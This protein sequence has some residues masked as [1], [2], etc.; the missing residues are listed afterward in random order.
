MTS[1]LF[2]AWRAFLAGLSTLIAVSVFGAPVLAQ[3]EVQLV[4]VV[5][6]KPGGVDA[7]VVV[8]C[9]DIGLRSAIF[10][11]RGDGGLALTLASHGYRVYLVD[12]WN[13]SMASDDGFDGVVTEAFPQIL[14]KVKSVANGAPVTFIGHGVCGLLPAAAAADP[15]GTALKYRWI[16]LGTRFAWHVV[17]PRHREWLQGF[18]DGARPLPGIA[19]SV[20][21]TGFRPGL[22]ARASS[23]PGTLPQ[24]GDIDETMYR[25]YDKSLYREP[26]AGVIEDLFR[27]MSAGAMVSRQGWVDYGRGLDAVEGDALLVSGMSDSVSPPEDVLAGVD[28]L[29]GRIGVAHRLLSRANGHREEYGHLG[30]LISRH[31]ARDVD[32]LILAWLAGRALP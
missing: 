2:D 15:R 9:P 12:P 7:E 30:M 4:P 1:T 29:A 11:S 21:L 17:S 3:E 27:W 32:R 26:P 19:K 24:D 28:R 8:L 10:M 13:T 5:S 31:A 6:G 14:A 16:G 18:L 22:G 25:F 23:V 20:L